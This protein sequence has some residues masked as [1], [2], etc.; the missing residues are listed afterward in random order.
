[1]RRR[2]VLDPALE[3]GKRGVGRGSGMAFVV[4]GEQGLWRPWA[5][6]EVDAETEAVAMA[7]AV[8]ILR[9]PADHGPEPGRMPRAARR[10]WKHQK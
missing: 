6:A 1:M 2:F 7:D 8:E 4:P 5:G 10:R 3:R 9:R